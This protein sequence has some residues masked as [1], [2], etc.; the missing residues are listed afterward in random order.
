LTGF[1]VRSIFVH[2]YSP[3]KTR[4]GYSLLLLMLLLLGACGR[5]AVEP[6]LEPELPVPSKTPTAIVVEPTAAPATE[7]P[8]ATIATPYNAAVTPLQAELG[9]PA[10]TVIALHQTGGFAGVDILTIIYEDGRID[11]PDGQQ[12]SAPP[13]DVA[14]QLAALNAAGFFEMTQPASKPICCDH[15]TYTLYARDGDRENVITVSGGDPDL[16]PDLLEFI[17][18]LQSLAV[19]APE[20]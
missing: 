1:F 6:T 19:D 13:E 2:F 4:N 8:E 14:G 18:A 16:A 5:E 7:Q 15:F 17:L 3:V 10:D 11:L 9:L 20:S 12:A